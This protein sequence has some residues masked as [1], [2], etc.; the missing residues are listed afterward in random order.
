MKLE[1]MHLYGTVND[2]ATDFIPI[3]LFFSVSP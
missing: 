1:I 2:N 3:H